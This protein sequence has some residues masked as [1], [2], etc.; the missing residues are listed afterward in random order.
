[1]SR[2]I[3]SMVLLLASIGGGFLPVLGA[4]KQRIRYIYEDVE[5][6]TTSGKIILSI[7][8]NKY[9]IEIT[10]IGQSE[11]TSASYL[12]KD[13]QTKVLDLT[14][15]KKESEEKDRQPSIK[16]KKIE[17][18]EESKANLKTDIFLVLYKG[19][20]LIL[21]ESE[22]GNFVDIFIPREKKPEILR[23]EKIKQAVESGYIDE[24]FL[25]NH[26]I[27]FIN[28]HGGKLEEVIDES[29]LK[30]SLER[31]R[32]GQEDQPL[33]VLEATKADGTKVEP[34][35]LILVDKNK[36]VVSSV[37]E[38]KKRIVSFKEEY[39]LK[40]MRGE[41]LKAD[42]Y[43]EKSLLDAL[44]N[45]INQNGTELKTVFTT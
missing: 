36:F 14:S 38:M 5:K 21:T 8:D 4:E 22:L 16:I 42:K 45:F 15:L 17:L 13:I 34:E 3:P 37:S 7:R 32:N 35:I 33:A 12:E 19:K 24:A 25:L 9:K 6:M 20:F 27:E 31:F 28:T 2:K 26:L 44:T 43:P 40:V 1:M 23:N 39:L 29:T 10:F 11:D 30:H 41:Q 18:G